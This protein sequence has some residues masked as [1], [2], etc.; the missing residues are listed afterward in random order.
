MTNHVLVV[1]ML[2]GESPQ[3]VANEYDLQKEKY[4]KLISLDVGVQDAEVE[5]MKE[6]VEVVMLVEEMVG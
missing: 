5:V 6:E 2:I 3:Y 1:F 4:S